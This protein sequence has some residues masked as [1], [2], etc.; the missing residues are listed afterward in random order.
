M[1]EKV[2]QQDGLIFVFRKK[3]L[4]KERVGEQRE[5]RLSFLKTDTPG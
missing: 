2:E 5:G 3:V 4:A 1:Y